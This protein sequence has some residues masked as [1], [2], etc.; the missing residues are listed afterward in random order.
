MGFAELT[1]VEQVADGEWTATLADGYRIGEVPNG[2]FAAV[3]PLRA[4]LAASGRPDPLSVTTHFL[5]PSQAGLA[6][7]RTEVVRSGRLM[8]TVSATFEQ[9]GKQRLQMVGV[10]GDFDLLDG[11]TFVEGAASIP[12]RSSCSPRLGGS[13]VDN[14]ATGEASGRVAYAEFVDRIDCWL[15]PTTVATLS[16]DEAQPAPARIAGWNRHADGSPI[17]AASLIMFADAFPPPIFN[18]GWGPSWVPT[19]ELTVHFRR[20][21]ETEWIAMQTQSR[22]ID[23]GLLEEDGEL[24][25]DGGNL[26]ALARQL[27][28]VLAPPPTPGD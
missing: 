11:P 9:Y 27:G 2:G 19:V 1:A 20:R 23:G 3:H 22:F 24:Y 8:T 15:D 21:V 25:D 16:S 14:D 12:D 13:D 4:M 26:V 10:F 17:D 5:R 7:I 6:T 18:T 28:L